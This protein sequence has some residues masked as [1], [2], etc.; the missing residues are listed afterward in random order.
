M[1]RNAMQCIGTRAPGHHTGTK[2]RRERDGPNG[3]TD[4]GD[5]RT[6]RRVGVPQPS[7]SVPLWARGVVPLELQRKPNRTEPNRWISDSPMR[8]ASLRLDDDDDDDTGMKA[9]RT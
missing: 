3:T 6:G 1:R 2:R 7:S 5:G 4:E 9:R 8:E